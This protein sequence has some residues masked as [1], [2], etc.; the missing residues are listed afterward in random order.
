MGQ[1]DMSA[2]TKFARQMRVEIVK[3]QPGISF[4]KIAK[5]LSRRWQEL[6]EEDKLAYEE[7]AAADKQ[8]KKNRVLTL[9]QDT[10]TSRRKSSEN[11]KLFKPLVVKKYHTVERINIELSDIKDRLKTRNAV[12]FDDDSPDIIANINEDLSIV[13]GKSSIN[14]FSCRRL[15]EA[16]KLHNNLRNMTI[17]LKVLEEGIEISK[18]DLGPLWDVLETLDSSVDVNLQANQ[19]LTR[20]IISDERITKNGFR[21]EKHGS[22]SGNKYTI[23]GVARNIPHFGLGDLKEVLTRISENESCRLM[24]CRPLGAVDLIRNE[25]VQSLAGQTFTRTDYNIDLYKHWYKGIRKHD[26]MCPHRRLVAKCI[27]QSSNDFVKT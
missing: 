21:I 17:D 18:K 6:Q 19:L 20:N 2:F 10:T 11:N 1:K 9:K 27:H 12:D 3:A 26:E 7:M 5:E 13:K 14:V 25:T 23:T 4:P 16:I 8:E 15:N 24:D 22:L